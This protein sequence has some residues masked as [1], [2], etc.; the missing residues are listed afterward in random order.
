MRY[1]LVLSLLCLAPSW[2]L[3]E[4]NQPNGTRIN[5]SAT[6]EQSVANDEMIV[7][8]RIEE[9]G[10]SAAKLRQKVNRTTA[11]LEARLKSEKVTHKTT[12]R[13]LRPHWEKGIFNFQKWNLSQSGQITTRDLDS[14]SSWLADI[15]AMGI[16]LNNLGFR[17]SSDKM[18]TVK[19][20][21][22]LGAL[23]KFRA[24]AAILSKGL[25][26][27]SFRI[28]RIQTS[29][30]AQPRY[31]SRP[32]LA[33]MSMARSAAAP[34]VTAGESKSTLTVSGEIEVPFTNFP[35]H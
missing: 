28:I 33:G 9:Q 29:G 25:A 3:A 21:L 26:A 32:M 35:I 24:K 4:N 6:A 30:T 1:L 2:A 16:K 11:R 5:L 18:R 23:K 15:E 14:I 27:K 20:A 8:Y 7:H 17:V 10:N 19:D 12:G 22:Q 34:V 31:E 13:S